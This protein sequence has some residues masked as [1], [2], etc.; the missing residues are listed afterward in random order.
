MERNTAAWILGGWIELAGL[1]EF[2][3]AIGR[4]VAGNRAGG[5]EQKM[6]SA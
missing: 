2:C 1:D 5:D 6:H 4:I 3:I